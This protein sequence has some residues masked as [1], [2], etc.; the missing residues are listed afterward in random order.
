[1]NYVS[2]RLQGN[3]RYPALRAGAETYSAFRTR[4]SPLI[5]NGRCRHWL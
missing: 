5:F 3:N 2:D 4:S 1:M